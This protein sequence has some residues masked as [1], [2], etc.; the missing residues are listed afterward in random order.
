MSYQT[1]EAPQSKDHQNLISPDG[2][3][4]VKQQKR[5]QLHLIISDEPG[6]SSKRELPACALQIMPLYPYQRDPSDKRRPLDGVDLHHI[7]MEAKQK[8]YV[9][10]Y[11]Q[12]NA[13]KVW[14][15]LAVS[16]STQHA[17]RNNERTRKMGHQKAT[18]SCQTLN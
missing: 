12:S 8:S 14:P 11:T 13:K 6:I 16:S 18:A 1:S 2:P 17:R 4:P 10:Y 5:L 3:F 15:N 7:Q 9:H